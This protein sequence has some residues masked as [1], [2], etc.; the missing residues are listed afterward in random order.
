MLNWNDPD[1]VFF[2][3]ETQSAADLREVGGRLYAEDPTTRVMSGVFWVNG[4][5]H[6]WVPP[7][8]VD[9][10]TA[11]KVDTKRL[12]SHQLG[13][14][15]PVTFYCTRTPPLAVRDAAL[16]GRTFVAHNVLGFDRFIWER[17]IAPLCR[18]A[19]PPWADTIPLARTAGFKASLDALAKQVLGGKKDPGKRIAKKYFRAAVVDGQL[20]YPTPGVGDLEVILRYNVADVDLLRRAWDKLDGTPVEADVIEV[21]DRINCRGIG[22]DQ[23]LAQKLINVSGESVNRAADTIK[24]LTAGELH[25]GNLR[26]PKQVN[27]WLHAK[28]VRIRDYNGKNTLRKDFITQALANPWLMVEDD[29]PAAAVQD[30]SPEVFDVLRLRAAALRITGAKGNRAILRAGRDGRARDLFTYWQAHTGRWASAGIQ[31]HNLPRP[32]KG[33]P[34]LDLLE[35]HESGAWTLNGAAGYDL[36]ASKLTGKLTVDDALS[37]LLRPMF[38]APCFAICDY[39]AIE[40]RVLAWHAGEEGLLH[41]LAT[42]GDVYKVMASKIFG[43]PVGEINDTE[44]QVGKVT[45]L[46]CGYGMS[47]E[48]FRLYVGLQGVDLYASGTTAEACVDAFRSLYPAIAGGIAGCIDGKPYRTGGIWTKLGKAAMAAVSEGGVHKA[49]RTAWTYAGGTLICNLPSGRQLRYRGT[50][51]EDRVPGYALALGQDK[52]K[53]TLVYEGAFGETATY[54]AKLCENVVQASSRDFMAT[55]AVRATPE[56]DLV[57]HA[58]DELAAETT[59]ERGEESL[60]LLA[61]VMCDVPEW[62]AGC[63]IAVEGHCAPRYLKKAPKDWPEVKKSAAA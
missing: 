20:T 30:I 56:L 5:Y 52:K 54:G 22:I 29:S 36:L 51:I 43:K 55:A 59:P 61:N 60:N 11:K 45:V 15:Q 42:G 33:V 3:L 50:R 12:W 18:D 46:G 35:L 7:H 21:H 62:G 48:K 23:E 49:C 13:P 32:K 25:S 4:V 34:V 58:H 44:R 1:P 2:D 9:P 27:A 24:D 8:M 16:A 31:V 47:A 63:P 57:L 28:G 40:C 10:A 37:S 38:K 19:V 41:E 14:E 6:V 53:A 39:A 17:L 26:S